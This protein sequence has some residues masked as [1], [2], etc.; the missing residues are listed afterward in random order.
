MSFH[1]GGEGQ[2]HGT[3]MKGLKVQL[4]GLLDAIVKALIEVDPQIV[5]IYQFGSSVYE[6]ELA[7]DVDILIVT[8][9]KKEYGVYLDAVA[10]CP[11]QV[12]VIVVEAGERLG[13]I[14]VSLI[15]TGEL[16]YGDGQLLQE[17]R[18]TVPAPTFDEARTTLIAADNNLSI[19]LQS[20]DELLQHKHMCIA[21]DILFHAA[22]IAVM[23]FLSTDEARWGELRRRL[24]EPFR[25]R[26]RRIIN[27]LH[28]DYA[29]NGEYPRDDPHGEY[30]RWRTIVVEFIDDLEAASDMRTV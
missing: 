7:R 23:A 15:A 19:A 5:E 13:D 16:L 29:Y 4:P 10:D 6:P 26:F 14:A 17:V 22:R 18:N 1:V 30:Q 25:E 8:A 27:T 21:F 12:D 2:M 20:S 11:I 28:I 24:M 9:R 3:L